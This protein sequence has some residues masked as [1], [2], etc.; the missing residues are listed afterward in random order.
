MQTSKRPTNLKFSTRQLFNCEYFFIMFNLKQIVNYSNEPMN[1]WNKI[2]A[3]TLFYKEIARLDDSL[4]LK[5]VIAPWTNGMLAS[6]CGYE[7]FPAPTT[8]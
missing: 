8:F 7:A 2:L 4:R 6:L 1:M 3:I 5:F